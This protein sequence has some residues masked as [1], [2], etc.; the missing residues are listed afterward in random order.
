M[1]FDWQTEEE[2]GW[3]EE[4][5]PTETAVAPSLWRRWRFLLVAVVGLAAVWGMVQWQVNQ[6]VTAATG[7][8][9]AEILS[10][11][12]FV[13]QT[14]VTQDEALFRANLSGRNPD[15]ADVQKT[16]LEDA[17]L[18]DRPMFG[19]RYAPEQPQLNADDVDH[20]LVP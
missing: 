10:T 3:Q 11:H 14:A 7:N 12:K 8:I 20:R 13:L 4:Q 5:K 6:R 1:S 19:W 2:S 9:E 17:L 18:L 15:W 16:L